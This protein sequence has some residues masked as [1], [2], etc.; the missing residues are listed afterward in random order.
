MTFSLLARLQ[1]ISLVLLIGLLCNLESSSEII[2]PTL[3]SEPRRCRNTRL[4]FM[5]L[6]AKVRETGVFR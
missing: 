3:G 5:W 1:D 6:A 4:A 2:G